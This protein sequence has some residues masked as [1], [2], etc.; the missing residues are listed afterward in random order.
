[1]GEKMPV[2]P[3]RVVSQKCLILLFINVKISATHMEVSANGTG[4]LRRREPA[5]DAVVGDDMILV[6][7]QRKLGLM[8]L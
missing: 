6:C 3:R 2:R 8:G 4:L 1:M 5:T 7:L